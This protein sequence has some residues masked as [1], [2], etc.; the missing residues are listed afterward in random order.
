MR[1][2][3]AS[4]LL[5]VG[6]FAAGC[7]STDTYAPVP[8]EPPAAGPER[9]AAAFERLRGLAGTWQGEFTHGD[10]KGPTAVRYRVTS[11]GSAVEEVLFGGT[12]HEMVTMYHLDGPRLLL[13]HYCAAGNQPTMVLAPGDDPS[14][15]RFGF[16]RA[17]NLKGPGDGHMH[18]AV[19]E[20][21]AP[22][23]LKSSWTFWAEGKPGD[24]AV[25]ETRRAEAK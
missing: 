24:T 13:T 18:E 1:L 22:D 15:L 6:A 9:P 3:A 11:G 21:P 7:S 14:V 2:L 4:A 8:Q 16:L 10:E 25:I 12:P 5:A 17:T 19:I 20:L 23:R